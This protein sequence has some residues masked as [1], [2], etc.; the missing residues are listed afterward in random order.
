MNI[1]YILKIIIIFIL[2]LSLILFIKNNNLKINNQLLMIEGMIDNNISGNKSFCDLHNGFD[3]EKSCN[4][5]SKYNC[6]LTDCC[7]FTNE[8]KCKA[9]NSLGATFNTDLN[10]KTIHSKY[11]YYK[12]TCYG[13]GCSN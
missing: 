6:G 1:K 12:N 13:N 9:G 8:N 4:K 2:I 7:V 3:L 5:L 11:Y 10:G